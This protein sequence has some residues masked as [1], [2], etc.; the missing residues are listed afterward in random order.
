LGTFVLPSHDCVANDTSTAAEETFMYLLLRL[1][2]G[3]RNRPRSSIQQLNILPHTCWGRGC[4]VLQFVAAKNIARLW[5]KKQNTHRN[6]FIPHIQNLQQGASLPHSMP[7]R[8]LA[9]VTTR[10]TLPMTSLLAGAQSTDNITR[11]TLLWRTVDAL[12][13]AAPDPIAKLQTLVTGT[14]TAWEPEQEA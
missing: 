12:G 11:A 5:H 3:F 9:S 10:H 6:L 2:L 13:S 7:H 1:K 4:D 14:L 8:L